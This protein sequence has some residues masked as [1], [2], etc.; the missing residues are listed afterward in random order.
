MNVCL[1][2]FDYSSRVQERA[3]WQEIVCM[4]NGTDNDFSAWINILRPAGKNT[5]C[6][7]KFQNGS[8]FYIVWVSRLEILNQFYE[9][10]T[11]GNDFLKNPDWK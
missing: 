4:Q 5:L 2:Q 1:Q 8:L 7:I 6:Q 11:H 10:L 3:C 9:I